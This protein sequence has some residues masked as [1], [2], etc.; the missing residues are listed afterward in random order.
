MSLEESLLK[1][2]DHLAHQMNVS[3][4]RLFALAVEEFIQ[5]RQNQALLESLNAVFEEPP[6][7]EEQQ[8]KQAM[9]QY[10]RELLSG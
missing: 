6:D 1:Q 9:R 5:R 8:R 7:S 3:R 10:H 4:S 2:A